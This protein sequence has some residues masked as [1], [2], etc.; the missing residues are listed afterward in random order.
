MDLLNRRTFLK[1]GPALLGSTTLL[2]ATLGPAEKIQI[3]CCVPLAKL[4]A[5]AHAGFDYIEPGA[6]SLAEL[7]NDQ[8]QEAKA[9]VLASPI[10]CQAFNS[11]IRRKD[12]VV[13]G[14]NVNLPAVKEYVDRTLD[15]CRQL[16]ASIVVWGSAGSRNV[17]A[18]FPRQ[19]AWEQI[20]KFLQAIAP[21]AARHNI[22][23]SLEPLNRKESN[24][25][26]TG[27]EALRM[28]K[29]VNRPEIQ[30]IIDY[31]HLRL[32]DEPLT[33][34]QQAQGHINHLHFARPQ[35]RIWPESPTGDPLYAPF[36][37]TLRRLHWSG[38]ISIE[39]KGSP[40]NNGRESLA[41]FR[42]ELA[43]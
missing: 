25:L 11:F 13:V 5:A 10:R 41:F 3:G 29:Q 19:R 4:S 7:S 24:I 16:G 17:P 6:A 27:G 35:G 1:T 31:Y 28:V 40:E 15:R 26:N 36:F 37:A 9:Q 20:A 8:F 21:L 32:E 33:I 39:G 34:F 12:L 23:I 42:R 22:V 18:D 30:M 14:P 2:P 38:G 43:G